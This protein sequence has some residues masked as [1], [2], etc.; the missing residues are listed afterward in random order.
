[1]LVGTFKIKFGAVDKLSPDT[2]GGTVTVSPRTAPPSLAGGSPEGGVTSTPCAA[3]KGFSATS[4][5]SL[6]ATVVAA[7]VVAAAFRTVGAAAA[8]AA[9]APPNKPPMPEIIPLMKASSSRIT[10]VRI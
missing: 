7:A 5:K 1:M 9:P 3:K 6:R 10:V 8:T 4:G 2:F